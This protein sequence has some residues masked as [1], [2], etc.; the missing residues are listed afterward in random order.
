MGA[1]SG[2]TWDVGSWTGSNGG[3]GNRHIYYIW[4]AVAG[5]SAFGTLSNVTSAP[6]QSSDETWCGFKPRLVILKKHDATGPWHMFDK[7]RSS[8]DTWNNRLQADSN[9][10]EDAP[11]NAGIVVTANGFYTQSDSAMT[12]NNLVWMAFA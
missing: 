7:F 10:I 4:K 3:S 9:A 1:N 12:S 5:V 11:S 8:T 2:R 6:T